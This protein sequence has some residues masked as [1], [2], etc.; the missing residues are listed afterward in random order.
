MSLAEGTGL[1]HTSLDVSSQ[2]QACSSDSQHTKSSCIALIRRLDDRERFGEAHR[3]QLSRQLLRVHCA[4]SM[5]IWSALACWLW[6]LLR[7]G[8]PSVSPATHAPLA[9]KAVADSSAPV[10]PF[11]CS[12]DIAVHMHCDSR[13]TNAEMHLG[14][15]EVYGS[16]TQPCSTCTPAL[17]P[18][19]HCIRR[20]TMN[21]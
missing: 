17:P 9:R 16:F 11:I 7:C 13:F 20:L 14:Q 19:P 5:Q 4:A 1:L 10:S 8:A 18:T 15:A 2:Q 12:S 6:A 21:F 3:K